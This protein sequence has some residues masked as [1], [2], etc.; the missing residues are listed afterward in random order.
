[1]VPPYCG[2]GCA[3]TTPARMDSPAAACS[4]VSSSASRRPAGPFRSVTTG[5]SV[6][7]HLSGL[8]RVCD[9]FLRLAL[10]AQAEERFALKVEQFLLGC[11]AGA[12]AVASAQDSRE[13]APD[14]RIV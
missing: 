5:M 2:C 6:P 10:A 13:R 9:S 1:M 7:E 11:G 14:N 12:D 3:K 4:G 8:Q